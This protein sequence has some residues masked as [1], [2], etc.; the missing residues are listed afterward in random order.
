MEHVSNNSSRGHNIKEKESLITCESRTGV[1]FLHKECLSPQSANLSHE[2]K[3]MISDDHVT[4]FIS[5]IASILPYEDDST[6]SPYNSMKA[7]KKIFWA[8]KIYLRFVPGYSIA[9]C[10]SQM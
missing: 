2:K 6:E 7:H 10:L 3:P 9:Q 1:I 5:Y 8:L 4:A